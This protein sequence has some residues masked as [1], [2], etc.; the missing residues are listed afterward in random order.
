[1]VYLQIRIYLR[2]TEINLVQYDCIWTIF[3]LPEYDYTEYH[4]PYILNRYNNY[5][6]K[7]IFKN[8]DIDIV[9]FNINKQDN[10]PL[11]Y[12]ILKNIDKKNLETL[13]RQKIKIDNIFIFNTMWIK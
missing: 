13:I 6:I 3:F 2:N 9:T 4:N 1:M 10:P 11:V 7:T 12:I 8:I 5:F